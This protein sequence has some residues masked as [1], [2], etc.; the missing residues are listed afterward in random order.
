MTTLNSTSL[1]LRWVAP[2]CPNGPI[3]GYRVYYRQA[4]STQTGTISSTGYI[5]LTVNETSFTDNTTRRFA[6][7]SSLRSLRNYTIHVRALTYYNGDTLLG[8]ADIELM[9]ML[10]TDTTA[11]SSQMLIPPTVI[12]NGQEVPSISPRAYTVFSVLPTR[13]AILANTTGNVT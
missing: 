11:A 6:I 1:L 3:S 2:D 5:T 8:N 4:N 13:D 9:E 12:V 10:D 7:I